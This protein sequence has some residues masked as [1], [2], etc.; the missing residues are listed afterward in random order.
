MLTDAERRRFMLALSPQY[1]QVM[2]AAT[3][4][5]LPTLEGQEKEV[6]ES[7]KHW[8]ALDYLGAMPSIDHMSWMMVRLIDRRGSMTRQESNNLADY[9]NAYVVAAVDN[10]IGAGVLTFAKDLDGVEF[11]SNTNFQG[12]PLSDEES[13]AIALIERLMSSSDAEDDDEVPTEVGE[14]DE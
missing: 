9:L 7:M 6:T 1:G 2:G 12:R 4:G 10:L 14:E 8:L 11:S 13:F 5:V 3:T